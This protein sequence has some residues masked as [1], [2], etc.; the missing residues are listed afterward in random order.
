[1]FNFSKPNGYTAIFNAVDMLRY[2]Y[3]FFFE[4]LADS[5]ANVNVVA[6]D[7]DTPLIYF[8]FLTTTHPD[9]YHRNKRA[10]NTNDPLERYFN[11][12][13]KHGVNIRTKGRGGE[14][15]FFYWLENTQILE[16]LINYTKEHYPNDLVNL[17]NTKN[18]HDGDTILHIL[19]LQEFDSMTKIQFLLEN[20][21]DAFIMNNNRKTAVD[22][23]GENLYEAIISSL[24]Q[25]DA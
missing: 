1:M 14:T 16:F 11:I 7:G 6:N 15:V 20:G 17:L 23:M 4:F 19:A 22:I 12:L 10:I 8:C 2:S 13:F 21:A 5:G 3:S 25:Q 24:P 18:T 9:Y